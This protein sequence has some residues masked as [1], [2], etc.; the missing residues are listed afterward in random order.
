MLCG[1]FHQNL[2]IMFLPLRHSC[3]HPLTAIPCFPFQLRISSQKYHFLFNQYKFFTTQNT[4][5]SNALQLVPLNL[6]TDNLT[7]YL[8]RTI[9]LDT[10]HWYD[11]LKCILNSSDRIIRTNILHFGDE[12]SGVKCIILCDLCIMDQLIKY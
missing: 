3:I 11:M 12:L 8:I 5:K 10:F 7:L 9:S 2:R 6:T 4:I 1:F